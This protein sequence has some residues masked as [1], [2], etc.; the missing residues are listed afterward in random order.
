MFC[1]IAS[2]YPPS[3][4]RLLWGSWNKLTPQRQL[5][6]LCFV[7]TWQKHGSWISAFTLNFYVLHFDYDE[8]MVFLCWC[9]ITS[10]HNNSSYTNKWY[11]EMKSKKLVECDFLAYTY[12]LFCVVTFSH[13]A[14]SNPVHRTM[15][16][17]AKLLIF[18]NYNKLNLLEPTFWKPKNEYMKYENRRFSYFIVYYVRLPLKF[19]YQ[20]ITF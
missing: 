13:S 4:W 7:R 14:G 11:R 2:S 6:R 17:V 8:R 5:T 10:I 16:T 3:Y 19:F 18:S 12:F 1:T 9:A 15:K 20:E